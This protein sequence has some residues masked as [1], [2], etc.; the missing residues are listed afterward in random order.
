[1]GCVDIVMLPCGA[2]RAGAPPAVT[3]RS[4]APTIPEV[5]VVQVT[6][7]YVDFENFICFFLLLWPHSRYV[8]VVGSISTG[9]NELL[10]INIFILS[11]MS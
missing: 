1:M 6:R 4:R 11:S 7:M 9:G 5:S 3:V 8:M 10:F 2:M